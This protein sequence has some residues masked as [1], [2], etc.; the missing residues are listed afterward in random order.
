MNDNAGTHPAF[1]PFDSAVKV[2]WWANGEQND[3]NDDENGFLEIQTQVEGQR[4][5]E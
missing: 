3:Q 5:A 1:I 2:V 4:L